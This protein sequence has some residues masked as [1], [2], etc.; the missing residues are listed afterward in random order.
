MLESNM[1]YSIMFENKEGDKMLRSAGAILYC[2]ATPDDKNITVAM[3]YDKYPKFRHDADEDV[4][5]SLYDP[6]CL[7][8]IVTKYFHSKNKYYVEFTRLD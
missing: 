8:T 4:D 6:L 7:H 1:S 2:L 5:I 3:N